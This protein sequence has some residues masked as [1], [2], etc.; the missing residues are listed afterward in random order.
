MLYDVCYQHHP[1]A[2]AFFHNIQDVV[3][4]VLLPAAHIRLQMTLRE[5]RC[6]G[7]FSCKTCQ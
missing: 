6:C 1:S 4:E 7:D 3:I 5:N 2:A